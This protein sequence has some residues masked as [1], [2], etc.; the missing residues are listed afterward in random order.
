MAVIKGFVAA[1]P[2]VREAFAGVVVRAVT[3]TGQDYGSMLPMKEI[4]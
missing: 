3:P 4:K 2:E 1:H